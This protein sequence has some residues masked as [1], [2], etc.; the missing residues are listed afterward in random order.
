MDDL[1]TLDVILPFMGEKAGPSCH[2]L[3][4]TEGGRDTTRL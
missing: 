4:V 3:K 2:L 1:H